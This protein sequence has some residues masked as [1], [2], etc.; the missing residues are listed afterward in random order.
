MA[1]PLACLLSNDKIE[2]MDRTIS[3]S[4]QR[5]SRGRHWLKIGLVIAVMIAAFVLFRS[6]LKTSITAKNFRIAQ[7][8]RGDMQNT[9]TAQG[10]V[11]PSFE[12]QVNAPIQTEILA[13]HK[14]PGDHVHPGELLLQLD[15]SYIQLEYESRKDQLELRKNNITR[16]QH[17]YTKT[18]NELDYDDQI[19]ALQVA[20]LQANLADVQR[21]KDIGGATQEEVEQAALNLQIAELEKKKLQN[22]LN[23]RK[24]V[25]TS[26]RRNLELEVMIQEKDL[27]ELAKKLKET[28]VK[29][30]GKGVVTWVNENIGQKVNEGDPL[31]KLANLNNFRVEASCSDR[32]ADLVKPGMPVQIR[33]NNTRLNGAVFSILPAVAN[34]TIE[35]V[36]G[37][38]EN[39]HP[40][41]RP[42][43]RVE[44]YV[45]SNK[46]ENVLRIANG[47]AFTG[48]VEQEVFVIR[49]QKAVKEKIRLGLTNTDFVEI[50]GGSL[51]EGDR[52]IISD[53]K[54]YQ[55]LTSI[56]IKQ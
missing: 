47:S 16:L 44:V 5:R 15:Q 27:E 21:L 35:F 55:H 11:I 37:L 34:N 26:D 14:K 31:V 22:E 48:A 46:K 20:N 42:N 51:Q 24:K 49:G 12:Q 1:Q 10:T 41:L 43:M 7:I 25:V 36:V 9:I 52:I 54:E 56:D 8:D 33:I 19:K 32:Y 39:N 13:I 28:Q 29:A 4:E 50:A 18:L 6:L 23:F 53:M 2:K 45:I 40:E 38:E 3:T 17:E 30:P